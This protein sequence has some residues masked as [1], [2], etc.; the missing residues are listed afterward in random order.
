MTPALIGDSKHPAFLGQ[1]TGK[2]LGETNVAFEVFLA[3]ITAMVD[4]IDARKFSNRKIVTN[5][6]V[7]Q[8]A[9]QIK[10]DRFEVRLFRKLKQRGRGKN[11]L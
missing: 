11:R 5:S 3:K 6:R 1:K 8:Y 10:V 9:L 4:L 7:R 2:V